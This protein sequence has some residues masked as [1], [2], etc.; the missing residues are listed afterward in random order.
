MGFVCIWLTLQCVIP[1]RHFLNP[2]NVSWTEEGHNFAWHMK[3]RDKSGRVRFRVVNRSDGSSWS[4]DPRDS[5]TSLAIP[6]HVHTS[7]DDSSVRAAPS[8]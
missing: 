4:V 8:Q 1:L 6:Q 5:L 2:G 7:G 3:L